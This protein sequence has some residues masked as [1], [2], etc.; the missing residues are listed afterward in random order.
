MSYIL[1]ESSAFINAKLTDYGRKQ[2]SLGKL[3]F[4]FWGL[5]DSEMDY[6]TLDSTFDLTTFNILRPKDNNPDIKYPLI[7]L[8]TDTDFYQT[9]TNLQSFE[10]KV[11]NQAKTRGFFT[12]TTDNLS[13]ITTNLGT[14]YINIGKTTNVEFTGGTIVSNIYEIGGFSTQIEPQVGDLVG[15]FYSH[16]N[17]PIPRTSLIDS[18]PE[19]ILFYKIEGLS[20]SLSGGTLSIEL[21]R[22]VPDF[23]LFPTLT[24]ETYFAFLPSGESITNFYGSGSTIPYW[25]NSTLIFD[26]TC[27]LS[28]DD[29]PVWNL[30]IPFSENLAGLQSTNENLNSYG[31]QT[32]L[33]SKELLDYTSQNS[34]QK[35]IAIIH[36]SN[37]NINNVYGERLNDNIFVLSL[38]HIMWHKRE[39]SGS[40]TG[41]RM[42]MTFTG[43]TVEKLLTFTGNT[44][45]ELRYYD[46]VD[47]SGNVVGKIFPDLKISI[48]ED[49]ELVAVL[50]YKSNRSYSLPEI[51]LGLET[52]SQTSL[53]EP[54]EELYVSYLFTT[55]SGYT[56]GLHC[57]YYSKVDR[58]GNSSPLNVSCFFDAVNESTF[59]YMTDGSDGRGFQTNNFYIICQKV[60]I[61]QRPNPENW[62]IIN[63][64]D[65]ALKFSGSD[66]L[67]PIEIENS[68]FIIDYNTYTG[69]TTYNINSFLDGLPLT[70][71]PNKLQFGDERF[72]FGNVDSKIE[73][74]TYKTNFLFTLKPNEF[75]ESINPTY[76]N[77]NRNVHITDI[78]IYDSDREL[79]GIGKLSSPIEKHNAKTVII[80]LGI[81]F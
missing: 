11:I 10:Q 38:P 24:G 60:V 3:N 43:D 13:A 25:N 75:N 74:T 41:D 73:A 42:G 50:S 26:G 46:L 78:A 63:F 4:S 58:I 59:P 29:V 17:N 56:N 36:Y 1:K 66:N 2:L 30:N 19:S 54:Y 51:K 33:G 55:N 28:T 23:S 57:Q 52:T 35:S 27:D 49:E 79:V 81:D 67:D 16:P 69:A 20:G 21:D 65:N 37:N 80:E 45:Y 44:N 22:E 53:L 47:F 68:T 77:G 39:F 34:N 32:Y 8:T 31:S 12:G 76:V 61:G 14:Y 71:E 70:N 40:T 62:K 5:G 64:T 15:I 18:I 6:Q 7:R 9:L 72:L 48:V